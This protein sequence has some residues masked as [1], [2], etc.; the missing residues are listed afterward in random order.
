[1]LSRYI[2][3]YNMS[4]KNLETEIKKNVLH[5]FI[6]KFYVKEFNKHD[7]FITYCSTILFSLQ[8]W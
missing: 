4:T 2:K 3:L 1:M 6:V 8:I 7:E 5:V